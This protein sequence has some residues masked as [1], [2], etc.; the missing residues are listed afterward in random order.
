M[1]KIYTLSLVLFGMV[2]GFAQVFTDDLNYADGALLTDNGW[3]AHNAAGTNAVTVGASNGL[4]YAGYSGVSGFTGSA[5]GNAALVDNT[6][7][8]VNKVFAAPVTSGTLYYSFLVNVTAAT[9]GGYFTHLGSGTSSFAARVFVKNSA[10]AGKINFGIS[11]T[12]TATYGTTDFDL[13]TTYLIVVK[14]EVATAGSVSIWVIP[15][16]IP[17]TEAAAGAAEATAS[18]GGLASIGAVYLRQ[19]DAAQNITV[20]GIYVDTAW[21]GGTPP[22]TCPLSLS[23][24]TRVCDAVT[25]GTDT[26][27]VTIPFTN[28][29]TD[30][31]TIN[32]DSGTVGGDD[33]SAAA[34]GNITISGVTE[35]TALVV[36]VTSSVCNL[37]VNV[38]SPTCT[39]APADA[40]LPY[41]NQFEYP[42]AAALGGQTNWANVNTGDDVV[43]AGGSLSYDSLPTAGNSVVFAGGGI[44]TFLSLQ[45]VA[46]GTVY[47]SFLLK[48]NTMAGVTDAN[49]GYFAGLGASTSNFGATLWTKRVDDASFNF[50]T[51]VRTANAANTTWTADAY[52]TGETY[53]VVVGYTFGDNASDDTVN[54]WINPTVGGAQPAATITDTHTGT[55]LTGI[56]KFFFRQDSATETPDVQ[57]DLLRVATTWEDVTGT[58]L[59]VGNNN[60]DG[61]KV[62][63]NP[64]TNGRLFIDSASNGTKTV[65]IY[66]VLG[67]QVLNTTT[68]SNEI[69]VAAIKGGVYIV[70]ITEEGKTATR[71]LVI[72]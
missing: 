46:T 68:S 59:S 58:N 26:Y 53:F 24:A 31:Y 62:Y 51:E 32:A 22:P 19:Y 3:T 17:A 42:E 72:K 43:V 36:T 60:I 34:S 52:A 65:A 11:N 25:A 37:T 69:N 4:S 33:P 44:D 21:F 14:Y 55:D 7:E 48:V 18:G 28:G 47:Y 27:T 56:S 45:N 29:G 57:V 5:E 6:G 64:V 63:P 23:T 12:S 67:K 10:N 30:N 39:P 20:D 38:T 13:N 16:G 50:G 49:G 70:K 2:S 1:K 41:A 61:L 66:D 35:G 15:S 9:A 8:D 71:K 40:A 54:L